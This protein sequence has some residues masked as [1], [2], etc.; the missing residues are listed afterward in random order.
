[1]SGKGKGK[2]APKK[3]SRQQQQRDA[4]DRRAVPASGSRG[5]AQAPVRPARETPRQTAA[6]A[7][8]AAANAANPARCYADV[9]VVQIQDWLGRTP[10]LKFRRGAS[11]LLSDA[12]ASDS[13]A[14]SLPAG[15]R[16]NTEAG[17]VDGVVAL[18][19]DGEN[20]NDGEGTGHASGTD[21]A[22][23]L[24]DAVHEVARRMRALMPHCAIQAVAG[25]AASYAEAYPAMARAR[26][27]GDYLLDWPPAP[28]ELFLAKPCDQCR[29]AASTAEKIQVTKDG[30]Y[31]LCEECH[32]R[33]KAAGR[34]AATER[35]APEPERRMRK[36]LASAGMRVAGFSDSFA[37]MAR[38]G[39]RDSDDASTQLALIYAD[40]NKV[41]AFLSKAAALADGPAKSEIAPALDSATLG[42]LAG[43]VRSRYSGWSK[44]PVLAHLAGGDDL[45][46][47]V[48]AADAWLF[49]FTLLAEF[50]G[51]LTAAT[52]TWVPAAREHPPS[53]SAGLVF[54]H[55][56][57]PFS[58][59]VRLAS[60]QL[61]AAKSA[62]SGSQASVAFLDLTADGSRPP[63]DRLPLSLD[64]LNKNSQR[65]QC[66]AD[67]PNSRRATL[68][69]LARQADQE[70]FIA[71]LT[72]FPNTPLW[73]LAAG[74]GATAQDVRQELRKDSAKRAELRRAL[75]V[76]RHWQA[77]PRKE[78][79]Q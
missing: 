29:Q 3:A 25:R 45:L 27:E 75:D 40:G 66:T 39:R 68:L 20:G 70:E 55:A 52:A 46:V 59:V 67:L 63:D 54:H 71:R 41:G 13:W 38:A 33:W 73:E 43:A 78:E 17:E 15:V 42:A 34:T 23:R 30:K 10:D 47:S 51:Q 37:D 62:T 64:Y 4:A 14:A 44:P 1:V 11:I 7:P 18:V 8:P 28:P 22:K 61:R 60:Q 32:A 26:R 56:K 12:T 24:E 57:D 50:S 35:L 36:A 58:D 53:L 48:P 79:D 9:A 2:S 49:V 72:D 16:R 76:A 31:D 6:D 74:K 19:A 21:G 5:S 69:E 77:G 65:F